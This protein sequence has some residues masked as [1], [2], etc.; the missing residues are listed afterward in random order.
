MTKKL[1]CLHTSAVHIKTFDDLLRKHNTDIELVHLVNEDLL[2]YHQK[3]GFVDDKLQTKIE[4]E[5]AKLAK[6]SNAILCTCSS[7]AQAAVGLAPKYNLPILRIDKPMAVKAISLGKRIVVLAALEST[8][9]TS[10][11]IV[12]TTI[13]E[14]NSDSQVIAKLCQG[15]W[16]YFEADDYN[17]YYQT[18]ADCIDNLAKNADVIVLAQASMAKAKEFCKADIP[19]LS[20]PELALQAALKYF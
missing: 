20:S 16:Q 15:A 19:V 11:E 13:K 7:I 2:E 10:L 18:I 8:L 4:L 14:N 5:I 9:E 17:K 6:D 1:A 3:L 12:K